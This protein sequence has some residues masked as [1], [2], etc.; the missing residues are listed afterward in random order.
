MYSSLKATIRL[1]TSSIAPPCESVCRVFVVPVVPGFT[2]RS[3]NFLGHPVWVS[4]RW[5]TQPTACLRPR[6]PQP[7]CTRQDDSIRPSQRAHNPSGRRRNSEPPHSDGRF[8]ARV[9]ALRRWTSCLGKRCRS[10]Q[11]VRSH[12]WTL[13]L[14]SRTHVDS[15]GFCMSSREKKVS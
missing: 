6:S 8:A 2:L 13:E 4:W 9:P 14:G 7:G 5:T 12:C 1:R 10:F 3:T 11:M 15:V